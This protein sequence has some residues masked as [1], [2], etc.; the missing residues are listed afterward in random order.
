LAGKSTAVD[1]NATDLWFE[2]LP[3]RLEGYEA[4]D[5]YNADETGFFF[6]CLPDRK[7][8]LKG[9]ICHG[10]KSVKERLMVLLCTNSNGP[11]KQVPITGKSVKPRCFQTVKKLSVTYY[12]N[13]KAWMTSELFKDYLH[14]LDASFSALGRK[15]LLY[16]DNCAAHSPDTS[17][18]RNIKVVY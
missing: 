13:S 2:R 8:A 4:R 17:S 16:V 1:T 12:A 18:L 7:R 15:I 10:E 9:E 3:E 5:I 6:N 11:G 14:A